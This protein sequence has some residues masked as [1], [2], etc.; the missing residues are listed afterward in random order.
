MGAYFYMYLTFIFTMFSIA[1][2]L[3]CICLSFAAIIMRMVYYTVQTET[4]FEEGKI[5]IKIL[6]VAGY[7]LAFIIISLISV[8]SICGT[9]YFMMYNITEIKYCYGTNVIN[10]LL[11]YR[12]DENTDMTGAKI[13]RTLIPFLRFGTLHSLFRT[14]STLYLI[15]SII[16]SIICG[17][18][19]TITIY[20]ILLF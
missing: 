10:I 16:V 7:L 12:Y 19:Y 11:G 17:S 5:L 1:V 20:S 18:L 3:L 9:L 8:I 4:Q 2:Y 14:L 6:I 15:S 13:Y